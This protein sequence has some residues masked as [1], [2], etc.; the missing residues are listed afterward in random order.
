[1]GRKLPRPLAPGLS[2]HVR[3]QCNNKEFRFESDED[4]SLYLSILEK[5][6]AQS[7]VVFY[8]YALMHTHVHLFL[9][10][11]GPHLLDTVMWRINRSFAHSY[12]RQR[13]RCGHLWMGPYAAS[14]VG[15]DQY[16]TACLRYLPCNAPKAGLVE[17][18]KGWPWCGYRF[19][20]YG[21]PNVLLTP[22]PTYLGF[23][24]YPVVRQEIYRQLV[25]SAVPDA[26]AAEEKWLMGKLRRY[27]GKRRSAATSQNGTW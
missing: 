19:Y 4:F 7:N 24:D 22:C 11:P 5:T 23:A 27:D 26:V 1:M 17:H 20:A 18:P 15:N 25:T 3:I 8:D 21:D 6:K 16:A 12:N 14:V 2:Y 13:S 10:T 9:M